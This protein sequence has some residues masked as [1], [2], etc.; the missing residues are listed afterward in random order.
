MTPLFLY[1]GWHTVPPS[2]YAREKM[3]QELFQLGTLPY[4]EGT[5]HGNLFYC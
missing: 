5:T 2:Y 4:Q 3:L 1:D